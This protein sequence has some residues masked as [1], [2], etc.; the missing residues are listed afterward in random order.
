[1]NNFDNIIPFL[2]VEIKQIH[3]I[4]H[5]SKWVET[6]ISPEYRIWSVTDG[7]IYI[8]QQKKIF[9]L[10]KGD[11]VLFSPGTHYTAYTDENGCKFAY[12]HFSIKIGNKIDILGD[13]NFSGIIPKEILASECLKYA[14]ESIKAC[15]EQ[16]C[17]SF[18]SYMRFIKYFDNIIDTIKSGN[19]IHFERTDTKAPKSKLYKVISYMGSYFNEPLSISQLA[20]MAELSEKYFSQQ[21]KNMLGISPKQYIMQCRMTF[22]ADKLLNSSDSIESI[23]LDSGYAGIYSFSKAFKKYYG[24]SPANYRTQNFSGS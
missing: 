7:K 8:S 5:N 16:T 23:A 2:R 3:F 18:K 15:V 4:S 9:S 10:G 1:M 22:A 14:N 21:F 17:S 19:I 11:I 20:Q 24:E 13:T 12:T 6:K